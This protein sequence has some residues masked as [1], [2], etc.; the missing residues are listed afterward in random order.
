MKNTLPRQT[1]SFRQLSRRFLE[2]ENRRHF[3]TEL[4]LF[5][6]IIA[7]SVWPILSLIDAM[8]RSIR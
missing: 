4:L 1:R 8:A 7:I 2:S 6:A 3:V 5:G